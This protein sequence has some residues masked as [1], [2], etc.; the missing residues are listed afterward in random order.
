M[1][2]IMNLKITILDSVSVD[3]NPTLNN[4]LSNK[5]YVDDS[6]GEGSI[7]RYNQT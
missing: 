5:N 4:E 3:G 2:R 6:I 1:I 7:L